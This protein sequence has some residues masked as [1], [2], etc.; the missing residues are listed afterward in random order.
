MHVQISWLNKTFPTANAAE[1]LPTVCV[2]MGDFKLLLCV[3]HFQIHC[4]Y[5]VTLLTGVNS[6]VFFQVSGID[7]AFSTFCAAEW[8]FTG[9]CFHVAF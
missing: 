1:S 2:F 6:D 4:T 8:F 9:V 5:K 3:K 7:K